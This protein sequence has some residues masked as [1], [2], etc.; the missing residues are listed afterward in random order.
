MPVLYLIPNLL[1][2]NTVPDVIPANI[3][4]RVHRIEHFFVE[5]LKVARR[6]LSVLKHPTPIDQLTFYEV[7]EHT[8]EKEMASLLPCLLKNDTGMISDAGVPGVADPGAMLA[9]MAHE[10]NVRVVPLTGP[11]SVLMALM[12]SGLNGQSFAFN[13]Y[14]PVKQNERKRRLSELEKRSIAEKQTQIFIETPYRN[15]KMLED[16]LHTCRDTTSLCIAADITGPGE[17]IKTKTVAGWKKA[18]PDLHKIPA[19][20]LLQGS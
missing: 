17:F 3:I 18:I 13:G 9:R 19:V 20:F 7:N 1:S 11:S 12:A 10:N 14:L 6:Y 15:M 5:D 16:I 4:T 2:A 8:G